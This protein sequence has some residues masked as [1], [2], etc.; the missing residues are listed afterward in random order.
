MT[1]P[2]LEFTLNGE[3]VS[4]NTATLNP[5]TTLA[6]YIRNE[7]R[8][9]G[10]KIACMEGGCGACTVTYEYQDATLGRSKISA[11]HSCLRPL[12][13]CHGATITTN[14]GLAMSAQKATGHMDPVQATLAAHNGSQCG[15]C[16]NGFVM[17][18]HALLAEN[19]SPSATE[20]ERMY[21]GNLCR[22]TGYRPI[23]DAMKTFAKPSEAGPCLKDKCC[24]KRDKSLGD[25]EEL[26]PPHPAKLKGV[27]GVLPAPAK[28]PTRPAHLPTPKPTR[29]A[30]REGNVMWHTSTTTADLRYWLKHYTSAGTPTMLVV[31]GTSLG[32]YKA[33]PNGP[34]TARIGIGEIT[35]LRQITQNANGITV[36]AACTLG[37]LLNYVEAATG[38]FAYSASHLAQFANHLQRVANKMVRDVA[39]IAGNVMMCHQHQTDP[40]DFFLSDVVTILYGIG[41]TLSVYNAMTDS[42]TTVTMDQFWGFDFGGCY[43]ESILIPWAVQGEVFMSY[44]IAIR[45]VNAKSLVNAAMRLTLGTGNVVTGQPVIVY[46]GLHTKAV[47][48]T[49]VETFLIGKNITAVATQ[50]GAITAFQSWC[51]PN[52]AI[53]PVPFRTS[54]ATNN[55]YR[56]LLCCQPSVPANLQTA[57]VPWFVRGVSSGTQSYAAPTASEAPA[58]V[59]MPKLEAIEQTSGRALYTDDSVATPDTLFAAVV[60]CPQGNCTLVSCDA[61]TASTVN[62]FVKMLT[63]ADM[64]AAQNAW[65]NGQLLSSGPI[66]CAGTV[67]AVV[68]AK[69]WLAAQTAAQMVSVTVKDAKANIVTVDQAVAANSFFTLPPPPQ[70]PPMSVGRGD[71]DAAIAAAGT[72]T[73]S[74]SVQLGY[75]YHFHLE[76]HATLVV[77]KEDGLDITCATQAPPMIQATCA[78]ATGLPQSKCVV[79]VKRCGG[80]FGG[81]IT[82][83]ILGAGIAAYCA[84][85]EQRPVKLVINFQDDEVPRLPRRQTLRLHGGVE[86][87][88]E[89]DH[90]AEGHAVLRRRA[91]PD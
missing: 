16:S 76:N 77:P 34:L 9:K 48:A 90:R 14:D 7:T 82:S 4:I 78:T 41:A 38:P 47:R 11:V 67:V 85:T 65:Q 88:D 53:G 50:T 64:P 15:Y 81:K 69:T 3:A 52:P 62:G 12:L 6:M 75:Q 32:V 56:F 68:L 17:A 27:K 43:L 71:P 74:G 26:K 20:I 8:W 58:S 1:A 18:M 21:D 51:N 13:A 57:T 23:L 70:A 25:L 33:D 44:K 29:H 45:Q 49:A 55:L 60:L 39:S 28:L 63:A 35:E 2:A 79:S 54:V 42:R 86:P 5:A 80:G 30:V 59:A 87:D 73:Y 36:G 83:S 22:C 46:G 91:E 84:Y 10:T 66:A 61:T 24:R 19:P 31:S 89:A 72:N 40:T 37:N